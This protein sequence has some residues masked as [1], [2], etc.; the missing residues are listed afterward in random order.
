[1]TRTFKISLALAALIVAMLTALLAVP[2]KG[3]TWKTLDDDNWCDTKGSTRYCE[4]REVTLSG[5]DDLSVTAVNGSITVEAW[6][7][8]EIRVQARV[9]VK[10]DDA[11]ETAAKVEIHTDGGDVYATGPKKEKKGWTRMFGGGD[12][13]W[14][15]SY[16]V[17]VPRD[18]ELA[19]KT[20]NGGISVTGVA[21]DIE[22]DTTNGGVKVINAGGNV[23]GSTTNGGVYV[24]LDPKA[25]GGDSIDLE[26]TN[27][28]IEVELPD[29]ID[30]RIE[31]RTT[32][33][34]VRVAHPVTIE[35][36]S[37]TRL[38]GTIGDGSKARLRARTTNGGVSFTR[39]SV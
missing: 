19:V 20:T 39:A 32:N 25:W 30:A 16:R 26:T 8:D 15:V 1:V 28:G 38:N 5:R 13:A 21:G 2:A 31:A 36:S 18:I 33:G 11:E 27:G 10:G 17:M 12:R 29:E 24:G 9:Q 7:G 22:F 6:D 37:R 23:E 4:V 34:G 35:K 3:E 14:R